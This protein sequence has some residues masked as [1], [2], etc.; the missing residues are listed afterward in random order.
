M[1]CVALWNL[2]NTFILQLLDLVPQ[3]EL[4]RVHEFGCDLGDATEV[5]YGMGMRA[6]PLKV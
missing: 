1:V 6:W 4:P 3:I 2:K 5:S